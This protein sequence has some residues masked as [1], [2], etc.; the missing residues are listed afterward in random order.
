MRSIFKM[1]IAFSVALSA[2]GGGDPEEQTLGAFF[3]AVQ[4][5]DRVGMDRVSLVEF[6]GRPQSW[7]ILERGTETAGPFEL[8]DLDAALDSKRTEVR[9]QRQENQNYISDN[10]DVYDAYI[11]KYTEDPSAPFQGELLVFH[12]EWQAKQTQLAQLEVDADQLAL[13][14]DALKNAATLSLRTPVDETFEGEIKVKPLQVKINDG[15]EDKTYTVVLHR[16]ELVSSEQART[17]NP[18]W[19]IAEIQPNS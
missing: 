10:R 3:N 13:D 12:E 9:R 19:I 14:I 18:Q 15:S 8:G 5:G 17:P 11:A 2:C 16:Y 4:K 6:G 7:E 1:V